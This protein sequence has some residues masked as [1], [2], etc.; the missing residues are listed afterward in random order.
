M[1]CQEPH[2]RYA[3][4]SWVSGPLF[5]RT[6]WTQPSL[7]TRQGDMILHNKTPK[8]H[9]RSLVQV[10]HTNSETNPLVQLGTPSLQLKHEQRDESELEV[11]VVR[12]SAHTAEL[13]TTLFDGAVVKL[14]FGVGGVA[15]GPV[16]VPIW[17]TAVIL[18]QI[19]L[20]M[21][22]WVYPGKSHRSFSSCKRLISVA[23]ECF[24]SIF[25]LL[26]SPLS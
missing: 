26:L 25:L 20:G 16:L 22:P 12:L 9:M 2:S 4:V 8:K 7:W 23:N 1:S 17:I 21:R 5:S 13:H 11:W 15:P 3:S 14:S 10:V 24:S 18:C 6:H 19:G